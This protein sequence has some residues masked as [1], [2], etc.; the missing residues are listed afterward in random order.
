MRF[1][2][3]FLLLTTATAL[4]VQRDMKTRIYRN[5][6]YQLGYFANFIR[7]VTALTLMRC[8][9]ACHSDDQCRLANYNSATLICSLIDESSFV[10]QILP[11]T[12]E[13]TVIVFQLCLHPS[14][15]EPTYLCFGSARPPVTVQ[16][17]IDN[18]RLVQNLSIPVYIARFSSTGLLYMQQHQND[19]ML[20]Y[21]INT[22]QQVQQFAFFSGIN[23]RNFD[24]DF[25]QKYFVMTG[26][27]VRNLFIST[28]SF[29]ATK[30]PSNQYWGICL[31][32]RYI[33]ATRN[34]ANTSVD[35]Y[36]RS[37]GSLA[38]QIQD[39]FA[40][41]GCGVIRDQLYLST[42]SYGIKSTNL[43]NRTGATI[44]NLSYGAYRPG[45]TNVAIDSSARLYT[46][47]AN[48]GTWPSCLGVAIC[49]LVSDGLNNS[50]MATMK[51][52]WYISGRASKYAYRY[53][54]S[55]P[56][57]SMLLIFDY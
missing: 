53:F 32:D 33:I 10:G 51:D 23:K 9:I 39:D 19:S 37:N 47:C 15:Q 25:V 20:V 45:W 26:H 28:A 22:Y 30:V 3:T 34:I 5:S 31:S 7:N 8:I 54:K 57:V 27:S 21:D 36:E 40:Y 16:Y 29:N 43:A 18:A 50:V 6:F 11:S 49:G 14:K 2:C 56:P 13:R 46:A 17:A 41:N 42:D 4:L 52:H 12:S 38:F 1:F 24:G 55:T 48:C 44:Q 35:V